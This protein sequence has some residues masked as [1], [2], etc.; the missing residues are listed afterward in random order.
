VKP[1]DQRHLHRWA[2]CNGKQVVLLNKKE[3][4]FKVSVAVAAKPKTTPLPG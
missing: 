2:E 1:K 4:F 3:G